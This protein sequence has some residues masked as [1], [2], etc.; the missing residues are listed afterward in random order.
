MFQVCINYNYFLGA[1]I[2]QT[3]SSKRGVV[4][5][6]ALSSHNNITNFFFCRIAFHVLRSLLYRLSKM[7]WFKKRWLF[8]CSS[9]QSLPVP[10]SSPW[11]QLKYPWRHHCQHQSSSNHQYSILS[12][13]PL[14]VA[15]KKCPVSRCHCSE[16]PKRKHWI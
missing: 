5:S 10:R 13:S 7:G 11:H 6:V 4:L 3:L 9:V 14:T 16:Q 12:T 8:T 2:L 15:R 1:F